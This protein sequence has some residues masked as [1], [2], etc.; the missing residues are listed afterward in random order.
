MPRLKSKLD[1]PNISKT[2]DFLVELSYI[3]PLS[4]KDPTL[5]NLYFGYTSVKDK[6]ITSLAKSFGGTLDGCGFSL[7]SG[8]RTLAVGFQTYIEALAFTDALAKTKIQAEVNAVLY[9]SPSLTEHLYVELDP[10]PYLIEY[11]FASKD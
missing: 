7:E 5:Y 1:I 11:S 6:P 4:Y 2:N 10:K 9:A 8:I 3:P